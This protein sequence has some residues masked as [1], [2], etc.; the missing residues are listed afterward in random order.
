MTTS[1]AAKANT[2]IRGSTDIINPANEALRGYRRQ[3]LAVESSVINAIIH[4]LDTG[5]HETCSR[6]DAS[7]YSITI[8]LILQANYCREGERGMYLLA[9]SIPPPYPL[10]YIADL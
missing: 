3:S 4:Q 10:Q 8:Q 9:V 6:L 7:L 5:G 1:V 2:I